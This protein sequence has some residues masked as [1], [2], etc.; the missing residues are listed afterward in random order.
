MAQQAKSVALLHFSHRFASLISQDSSGLLSL[1]RL[2]DDFSSP[3]L[4]QEAR[5]GKL[6]GSAGSEGYSIV[7]CS[8]ESV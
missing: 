3:K 2:C 5:D 6:L 1:H 8:V 4:P 7:A